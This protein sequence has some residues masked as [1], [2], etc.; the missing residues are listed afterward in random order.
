MATNP[1]FKINRGAADYSG[2]FDHDEK[3]LNRFAERRSR[4]AA[5]LNAANHVAA[6]IRCFFNSSD[7]QLMVQKVLTTAIELTK[8]DFGNIQVLRPKSGTL[9]IV[10]QRGFGSEFLTY[11]DQVHEGEAACGTALQTRQRVLVEDV[12]CDP[13]F[14]RS[15][16]TIEVMLAAEVRGVQSTPLTGPTGNFVGV[17]STHYRTPRVPSD[18]Q[19]RALDAVA[20]AVGDFMDWKRSMRCV[21]TTKFFEH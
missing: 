14:C 7:F 3:W 16:K 11:F 9:K 5:E 10:A 18:S 15:T 19:L 17:L 20:W 13:I 4:I 12:T 8:A 1:K 6:L 21:T 2:S